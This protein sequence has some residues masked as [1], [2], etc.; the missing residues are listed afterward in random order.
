M[1][2]TQEL[3]R[4][5]AELR[6]EDLPADVVQT[7]KGAIRDAVG[8][9]LFASGMPWSRIA[10][11]VAIELG[12]GGTSTIWG[13]G[14]TATPAYAALANGTAI[15][16]V[17]MDDRSATLDIHNGAP[18][19]SAAIATGE[20]VGATGRDLIVGV[21]CGYEVAFRVARATKGIKSHYWSAIR[22]VFGGAAAASRILELDERAYVNA[23]GITGSM[24]SGLSEVFAG[25]EGEVPMLKRLQGG[26]WPGHNGVM[27]A[28]LA[29][30][31]LTAPATIFEG[32][33][34]VIKSFVTVGDGDVGALTRDL[35][36]DFQ[37]RYWEMKSYAAIGGAQS[38]I[39]AARELRAAQSLEADDVERIEVRC[40]NKL[41]N[42]GKWTPRPTTLTGAQYHVPTLIAACFFHDLRDPS[43][44]ERPIWE[45]P[46]L[47]ALADRVEPLL[48]DEIEEIYRTTNDNGGVL[49]T[50]TR[51]DGRQH[52][53][54][55]RHPSGSLEN[56]L[57]DEGLRGKFR[58]LSGHALGGDEVARLEALLD[59]L[60]DGVTARE[61]GGAL[62]VGTPAGR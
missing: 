53:L 27:A 19:V 52:A 20:Y 42:E 55:Y 26:G 37:M 33:R 21:V 31:G 16:G 13:T 49:M 59:R 24:A 45:D 25:Q 62:A 36:S 30:A 15:H 3:A 6:Y 54:R 14:R 18:T 8:V 1:R 23:L 48:D 60:D 51:R 39:D 47:Q 46:A 28:I 2:E 57:S 10:A 5:V 58:V 35:G 11:D 50:I 44:W 34:G 4:F 38:T 29:R 9:G 40:S 56:P 43:T 17:E 12:G 61:L 32:E 41:L 7:A 22:A